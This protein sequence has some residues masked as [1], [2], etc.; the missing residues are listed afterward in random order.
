[1]NGTLKEE[2]NNS[3]LK[4][5]YIAQQI[6]VNPTVLSLCIRGDRTLSPDREQKLKELLKKVS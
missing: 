4:K 5:K 3:P 2:I 6:G 1:M